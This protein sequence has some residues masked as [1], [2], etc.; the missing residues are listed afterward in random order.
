MAWKKFHWFFQFSGAGRH[1]MSATTKI[2]VLGVIGR[3]WVTLRLHLHY[4][5][6]TLRYMLRSEWERSDRTFLVPLLLIMVAVLLSTLRGISK[7]ALISDKLL[8]LLIRTRLR[9]FGKLR[10]SFSSWCSLFRHWCVW[11]TLIIRK[12]LLKIINRRETSL[13]VFLYHEKRD[14]KSALAP[15]RA[16]PPGPPKTPFLGLPKSRPSP[17]QKCAKKCVFGRKSV[18]FW[19]FCAQF[20]TKMTSFLRT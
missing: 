2:M 6:I 11:N 3:W 4:I 19:P 8:I 13:G 7:P 9:P 20:C 14:T 10:M 16:R 15:R 17:L 12:F 1:T 5:I 18:H